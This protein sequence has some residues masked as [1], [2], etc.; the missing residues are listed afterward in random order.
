MEQ[1]IQNNMDLLVPLGVAI[2]YEIIAHL[3]T[4]VNSYV[5]LASKILKTV[6]GR[7]K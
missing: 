1:F 7:I 5:Q 3:P 4:E 2:A 6:V